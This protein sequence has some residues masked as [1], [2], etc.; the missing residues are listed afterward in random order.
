MKKNYVYQSSKT[1]D[2]PVPFHAFGS[3]QP[4][5]VREALQVSPGE[6]IAETGCGFY[7]TPL[8][9]EIARANGLVLHSYV[10]DMEWAKHFAHFDET[11]Y[12]QIKV[13][14]DAFDY[15]GTFYKLAFVDHERA[16]KFRMPVL[17]TMLSRA[18][19]VVA[20]DAEH[21]DLTGL[22]AEVYT[23]LHPHTAVIR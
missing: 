12:K 7:S 22:N 13:N 15:P 8:L 6:F 1:K 2:G 18:K 20:H 9:Y 19:V 10:E 17:K 4:A 3:H 21:L 23:W 11:Y 16:P 5:L 14:F